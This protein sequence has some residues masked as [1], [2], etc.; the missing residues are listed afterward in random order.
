MEDHTV[1]WHSLLALVVTI[2]WSTCVVAENLPKTKADK[3]AAREAAARDV[4]VLEAVLVD[5]V[6]HPDSPVE[7]KK[8][9]KKRIFFSTDAPTYQ[10]QAAEVLRTSDDKKLEKLSKEQLA[11]ARVAAQHLARRAAKKDVFKVFVPK[12]KRI[13]MYSKEEADKDKDLYSSRQRPQVFY[14]Y[15]PG[16]SADQQL[17]VVHLSFTWSGNLHGAAGTYVLTKQKDEWIVILRNFTFFL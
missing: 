9:S 12:D 16:Y 8:E 3:D 14:A 1:T 15:P 6:S 5:L 7:T 11:S 10:V 2:V 17:A 13:T 4:A